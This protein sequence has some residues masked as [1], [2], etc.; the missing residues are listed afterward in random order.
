M[1]LIVRYGARG[2]L[3]AP[4]AWTATEYGRLDALRRLPVGAPRLQPGAV[5]ASRAGREHRRR[6]RRFDHRRSGQHGARVGLVSSD[7][8][9]R[10]RCPS[11]RSLSLVAIAFWGVAPICPTGTARSPR[12]ARLRVGIVQG[13]VPQD[14]KWDP[15]QAREIFDRYLRLTQRRSPARAADPLAR[16]GD[17]VLFRRL[18]SRDR[19][20]AGAGA[21]AA[22]RHSD[23]QRSVGG[24]RRR[25]RSTTPPSC[26]SPT[27]RPAASIGRCIS[28][29]S[30]STCRSSRCCSSRRRWSRPCR[31]FRQAPAVNT[32]P[33][34]GGAYLDGDLL[35][36]RLSGSDSRRRAR[37]Q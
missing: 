6:V 17:A 20:T 3:L 1:P 8:A 34:G 32:L 24:G 29:R 12:D 30:G 22:R 15:A 31:I 27:G 5:A 16:V 10:D 35:R 23:R 37:R 28:C 14:Q 2:V 9:E 21:A 26:C 25:R 33:V 7:P 11:P 13:N 18:G 4:L 19:R 36:G